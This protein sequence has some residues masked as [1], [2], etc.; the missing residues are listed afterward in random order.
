LLLIY[1]ALITAY[2]VWELITGHTAGV[3]L[4]RLHAPVWWGAFLLVTGV[5]YVVVFRPRPGR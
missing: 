2:G 3:T 5:F 1:G 4:A